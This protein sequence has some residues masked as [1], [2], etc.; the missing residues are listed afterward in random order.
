MSLEALALGDWKQLAEVCLSGRD[1]LLWKTE[2][3]NNTR[4]QLR[5]IGPNK[6][7]FFKKILVSKGSY[8]ETDEQLDFDI[9]AYAQINAASKKA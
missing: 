2:F 4:S 3:T 7:L 6:F 5:E 9:A 8:T 1:Y